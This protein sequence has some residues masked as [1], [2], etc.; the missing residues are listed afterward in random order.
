MNIPTRTANG[1]KNRV[2]RK[3]AI[4]PTIPDQLRLL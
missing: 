3:A 4:V 2:S 1:R